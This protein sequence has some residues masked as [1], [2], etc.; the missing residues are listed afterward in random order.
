MQERTPYYDLT[1]T[2]LT[3]SEEISVYFLDERSVGQRPSDYFA[4]IS[5]RVV[6]P[7]KTAAPLVAEERGCVSRPVQ[8]ITTL[9][10]PTI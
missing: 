2:S 10:P 9:R 3:P 7:N 5:F 8:R 1:K 4:L 6:Q